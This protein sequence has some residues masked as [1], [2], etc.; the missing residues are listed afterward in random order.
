MSRHLKRIEDL[1]RATKPLAILVHVLPKRTE[2]QAIAAH[3]RKHGPIPK[4][5]P[6]IVIQHTF[7]SSL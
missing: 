5:V 1:E 3:V 4:G 2:A 6:V 7:T